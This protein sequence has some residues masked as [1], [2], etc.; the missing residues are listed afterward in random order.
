MLIDDIQKNN[1]R[2]VHWIQDRGRRNISSGDARQDLKKVAK[3]KKKDGNDRIQE[4]VNK[5]KIVIETNC[6]SSMEYHVIT[7]KTNS[8]IKHCC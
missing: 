6:L 5:R 7:G 1:K 2:K 4:T 3:G 8:F